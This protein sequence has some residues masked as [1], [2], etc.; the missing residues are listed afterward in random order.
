MDHVHIVPS[1]EAESLTPVPLSIAVAARKGWGGKDPSFTVVYVDDFKLGKVQHYD[2][3]QPALLASAS[4]ASDHPGVFGPEESGDNPISAPSRGTDWD[5]TGD[6]L[7]F[8]ITTC[9]MQ[10]PVPTRKPQ[11]NPGL[12]KDMW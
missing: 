11:E 10:I 4:L 3:G 7:S 2:D 1:W 8:T 6:A 5:T 9:S 12:L